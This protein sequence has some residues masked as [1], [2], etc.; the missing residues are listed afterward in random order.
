ME[1]SLS[2]SGSVRRMASTRR[3][4]PLVS[5]T[6]SY[7]VATQS[8]AQNVQTPATD[9]TRRHPPVMPFNS[10]PVSSMNPTPHS[11]PHAESAVRQ[12]YGAAAQATE[13]GLCCP[14]QYDRRFLEIIPAEVI[15]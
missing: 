11:Q 14:V 8:T 1:G 6:V 4:D 10:N 15:D 5:P 7:L 2:S 9:A 3:P 13:P 12:R